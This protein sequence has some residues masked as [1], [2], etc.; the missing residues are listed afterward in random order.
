MDKATIKQIIFKKTKIEEANLLKYVAVL[1]SGK[2]LNKFYLEKETIPKV[3][4]LKIEIEEAKTEPKETDLIIEKA[5][6]LQV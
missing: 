4:K 2:K 3:I 5:Q 1:H 6:S